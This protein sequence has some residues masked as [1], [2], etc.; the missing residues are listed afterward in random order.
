MENIATSSNSS[1]SN[2]WL[3][4]ISKIVKTLDSKMKEDMS[5][6]TKKLKVIKSTRTSNNI[7]LSK[8]IRSS[9]VDNSSSI[10]HKI[11]EDQFNS[12]SSNRLMTLN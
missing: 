10:S 4:K 7:L 1:N 8:A 5:I 2:S 12:C 3:I 6:A 9:K 11:K